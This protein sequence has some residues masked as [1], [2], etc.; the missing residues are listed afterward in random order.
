MAI[1][2]LNHIGS[3][4]ACTGRP[5]RQ[6][7]Q[8]MMTVREMQSPRHVNDYL[9]ALEKASLTAYG[10]DWK[11]LLE[12]INGHYPRQASPK[13]RKGRSRGLC[14][15]D[16]G[17][18]GVREASASRRGSMTVTAAGQGRDRPR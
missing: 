14:R 10:I 15:F 9:M 1:T 8:R 4:A 18:R 12:G 5:F 6:G 3:A 11:T 13:K 17:R 2:T 7:L 16:E